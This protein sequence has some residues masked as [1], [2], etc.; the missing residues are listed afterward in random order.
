MSIPPEPEGQ[1]IFKALF[2]FNGT[3]Y[4]YWKAKMKIFVQASDKRVCCAIEKG[5]YIPTKREGEKDVPKP[6]DEW[7]D[8]DHQKD[9]LNFKAINIFYCAVKLEEFK[10]SVWC[11]TA[12]EMWDK[13]ELTYEGTKDVWRAR[14]ATLSK[15]FS[16][17]HQQEG[18][19]IL[20]TFNK[21]EK[22]VNDLNALKNPKS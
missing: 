21:F 4:S 16:L 6:Q 19:P 9:E 10:K 13:L 8:E 3:N 11:T 1:S 7:V 12:K 17:F 2:F 14:I 5:S 15:K 22:I 20:E 18:E